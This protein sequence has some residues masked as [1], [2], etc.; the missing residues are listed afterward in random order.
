MSEENHNGIKFTTLKEAEIKAIET[1]SEYDWP[2]EVPLD[3]VNLR[4]HEVNRVNE[5]VATDC[6]TDFADIAQC[7]VFDEQMMAQSE[8]ISQYQK[9]VLSSQHAQMVGAQYGAPRDLCYDT[10]RAVE[11]FYDL[12]RILDS[13]HPEARQMMIGMIRSL[14]N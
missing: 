8:A 1:P 11:A 3:T 14:Y 7:R 9:L 6:S 5:C 12:K 2:S 4:P 10:H 13:A